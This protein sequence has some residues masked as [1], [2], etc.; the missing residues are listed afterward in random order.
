M[1]YREFDHRNGQPASPGIG[2]HEINP[3]TLEPIGFPKLILKEAKVEGPHLYKREGWY[4]LFLAAG[5]TGPGHHEKIA[6]CKNIFGPYEYADRSLL[7]TASDSPDHPI[8]KAGHGSL[9]D[10]P[11]GDW[12]ITHLGARPIGAEKRCPLGRETFIQKVEWTEDS[13]LKLDGDTHLPKINV[14]APV[15]AEVQPISSNRYPR[16]LFKDHFNS[17]KL[18]IQYQFPREPADESWICLDR[19]PSHLSLRG[20]AAM[21]NIFSQSLAAVRIHSTK[22]S[23]ECKLNFQPENYRHSAGLSCYY[24][25]KYFYYLHM[26]HHEKHGIILDLVSMLS[27]GTWKEEISEK[28]KLD[29]EDVFMRFTVNEADLQFYYST[30]GANWQ[31]AGPLLDFT[32]L[33]DEMTRGFTGSMAALSCEDMMFEK[34]WAHFDFFQYKS[35]AT[36]SRVLR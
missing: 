29:S 11:E 16:T 3:E 34:K 19:K 1:V 18:D 6:R 35:E 33:S 28:I 17:G 9:V 4:Y 2:L 5:G 23:F 31:A 36:F 14:P 27:N 13:W 22:M 15:Q 8:Q 25:S 26:T 30:N 20:R 7:I 32:Q 24:N 10:T 12:Y 21:S